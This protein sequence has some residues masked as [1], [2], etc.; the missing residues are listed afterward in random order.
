MADV[1]FGTILRYE[2]TMLNVFPKNAL[3]SFDLIV[4]HLIYTKCLKKQTKI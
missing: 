4:A 3:K 2:R 1:L